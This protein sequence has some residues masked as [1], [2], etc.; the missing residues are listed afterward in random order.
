M[1]YGVMTCPRC[2]EWIDEFDWDNHVCRLP[3]VEKVE[4]ETRL[5]KPVEIRVK[6][7]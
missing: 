6:K 7:R 1:C 2:G 4:E 5:E 3:A